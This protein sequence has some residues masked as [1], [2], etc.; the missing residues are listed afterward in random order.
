MITRRFHSTNLY[1]CLVYSE[2]ILR[3]NH[4]SKHRQIDQHSEQPQLQSSTSTRGQTDAASS[5]RWTRRTSRH[6][7]R[8]KIAQASQ[9]RVRNINGT[10]ASRNYCAQDAQWQKSVKTVLFD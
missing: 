9:R 8:A 5:T 3:H 6:G 1:P 10:R 4:A 7:R 2:N